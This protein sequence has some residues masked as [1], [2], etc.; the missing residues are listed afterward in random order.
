M[1]LSDSIRDELTRE[2]KAL[3]IQSLIGSAL[4]QPKWNDMVNSI[5]NKMGLMDAAEDTFNHYKKRA[6]E[7]QNG[8]Q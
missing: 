6:E 5:F 1:A 7:K 3:I 4:R 2:E 8:S